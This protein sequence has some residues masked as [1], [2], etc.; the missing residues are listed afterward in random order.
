[1]TAVDFLLEKITL[2]KLEHDVYLY[3]RVTYKDIEQAK[4][5]ESDFIIKFAD[6][7]NVNAYKYPTKTTTSELLLIFKNQL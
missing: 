4:E 7:V 3:P 1:M 6:W 2:K 5:M